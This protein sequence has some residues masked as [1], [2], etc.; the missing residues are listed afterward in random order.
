MGK[1]PENIEEA[2][3]LVWSTIS[4]DLTWEKAKDEVLRLNH[5]TY[6]KTGKIAPGGYSYWNLPL[7]EDLQNAL[8]EDSKSGGHLFS[9]GDIFWTYNVS[10]YRIVKDED[11]NLVFDSSEVST[12][13]DKN[14]Q[15]GNRFNA[16]CYHEVGM[17]D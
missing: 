2:P 17:G 1:S 9:E 7:L 16:I 4:R 3:K 14:L 6:T 12:D 10:A 8:T 13:L 11:D 5:Q 15:G